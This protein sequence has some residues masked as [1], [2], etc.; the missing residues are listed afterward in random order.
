ML[1]SATL[2]KV[3]PSR[4]FRSRVVFLCVYS[5]FDSSPINLRPCT[6]TNYIIHIIANCAIVREVDT[7]IVIIGNNSRVGEETI[8]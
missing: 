7:M 3:N 6:D 5:L 1:L 8:R 2:L 4:S